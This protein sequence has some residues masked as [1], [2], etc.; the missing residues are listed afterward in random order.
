M[1]GVTELFSAKIV[2]E[3]PRLIDFWLK[4]GTHGLRLEC[5]S[6]GAQSQ[7]YYCSSESVRLCGGRPSVPKLG[8]EKEKD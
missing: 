8:H 6:Q 2:S 3:E 1:G 4:P 5:V 7:V